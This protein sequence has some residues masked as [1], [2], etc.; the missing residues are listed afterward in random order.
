TLQLA[1]LGA[2]VIKI[3]EP[4]GGDYARA[5]SPALFGIVNRG[6]KSVTLDLRQAA[7]VA[8]FKDMVRTADVVIESFRPG[9]MDKLGCGYEVL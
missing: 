7:D 5:M 6:K 9:V 3:E 1:Q 8:A 4:N 2:E